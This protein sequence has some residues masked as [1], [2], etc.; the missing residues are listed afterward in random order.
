MLGVNAGAGRV[1]ESLD[2][3][4]TSSFDHVEGYHRV[5]EQ[6]AGVVGLNEAHSA[7]QSCIQYM[8]VHI[9]RR[10]KYHIGS[11]IEDPIDTLGNLKTALEAAQVD[12]V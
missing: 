2:F 4:L 12:K 9:Y 8:H 6:D 5:V 7:L 1:K 11:E 3:I 10:S